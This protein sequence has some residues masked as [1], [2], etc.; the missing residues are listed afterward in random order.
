VQPLGPVPASAVAVAR[1]ALA[2][3]FRVR[4]V[5]LPARPLPPAAYY[6]P[7]GRYRA[8]RLLPWLARNAPAGADRIIGL[9]ARDISVTKGPHVDWG[10]F[11]YGGGKSAVVSTYRLH[12]RGATEARF[13]TRLARVMAHEAGHTLGL[14]HCPTPHCLMENLNGSIASVDAQQDAFCPDCRTKLGGW[15]R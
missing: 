12:A 7:R 8:D 1:D 15:V 3:W 13:R 11:G 9:T 10:V 14:P 2:R 5:I 6:P 4:A